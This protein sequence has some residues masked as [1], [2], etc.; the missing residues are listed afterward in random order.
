ME[1]KTDLPERLKQ[2]EKLS[3][4]KKQ[5][6]AAKAPKQAKEPKPPAQKKEKIPNAPAE[7]TDP[8]H[9]FKHGFLDIVYKEKSTK[10]VV[11]RFPP[12]PNGYCIAP[13][14]LLSPV[15][16]STVLRAREL[17]PSLVHIGHS[18]AIAINFGFARY[19]GGDCYL[20]FDDT[21]PEAEEEKYFIAIREM[22]EWLGYKPYSITYSSDHF[23]KLYELAEGLIKRDGAYV[24]HCSGEHN[25]EL[26]LVVMTDVFKKQILRSRNNAGKARAFHVT[27][28]LTVTDRLKNH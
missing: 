22:I 18:K 1:D 14:P 28:V 27:A 17:I 19:H 8:N 12:E 23:E 4:A 25:L 7:P 16:F 3:K 13:F 10:H 20:R 11:T 5:P 2:D 24:C 26:L 15:S 6:K 21:N 9:M